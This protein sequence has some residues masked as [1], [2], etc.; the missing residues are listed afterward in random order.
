MLAKC[1]G[2]EINLNSDSSAHTKMH[3]VSYE[4]NHSNYNM[5]KQSLRTS[6]PWGERPAQCRAMEQSLEGDPAASDC[7][8]AYTSGQTKIYHT[9]SGDKEQA[10]NI[11][12]LQT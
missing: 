8:K 2:K 6:F 4:P 12:L 10:K 3:L 9:K 7:G 1:Q 11:F 5:E